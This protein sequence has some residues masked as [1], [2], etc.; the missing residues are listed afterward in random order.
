MCATIF[1]QA[2]SNNSFYDT[3]IVI[4]NICDE[5]CRTSVQTYVECMFIKIGLMHATDI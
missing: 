1:C 4:V 2:K 5:L 3:Y